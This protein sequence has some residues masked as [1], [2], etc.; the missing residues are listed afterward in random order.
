VVAAVMVGGCGQSA[1][2][3]IV[4]GATSS[5][6]VVTGVAPS[7]KVVARV[8]AKQR[9]VDRTAARLKRQAAVLVAKQDRA[10][11]RSHEHRKPVSEAEK[12]LVV[13]RVKRLVD[14]RSAAQ[15]SVC[16]DHARS[17]LLKS[18]GKRFPSASQID[19]LLR[20]CASGPVVPKAKARAGTRRGGGNR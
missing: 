11:A 2:S 20:A 16:V 13:A 7:A 4:P 14:A 6:S 10:Y 1:R 3:S 5:A 12:K 8:V 9:A 15:V 18:L 19:S 17:R